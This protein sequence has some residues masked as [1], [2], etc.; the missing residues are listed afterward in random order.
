M[1]RETWKTAWSAFR[2][3][4]PRRE[5]DAQGNVW[6]ASARL[7]DIWMWR[8]GRPENN[9]ARRHTTVRHHTTVSYL[10][11]MLYHSRTFGKRSRRVFAAALR[12]CPCIPVPR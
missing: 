8:S 5:F 10:M 1:N 3:A 11:V 4:N 2:L 6:T 12:Q 9:Q 7:G